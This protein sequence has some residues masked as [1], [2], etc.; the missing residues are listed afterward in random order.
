MFGTCEKLVLK[1]EIEIWTR[2][3][4]RIKEIRFQCYDQFYKEYKKIDLLKKELFDRK[5]DIYNTFV[6]V[7]KDGVSREFQENE[8]AQVGGACIM[9]KTKWMKSYDEDLGEKL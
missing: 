5:N 9:L 8:F 7:G 2:L 1:L 4:L 3:R 6:E